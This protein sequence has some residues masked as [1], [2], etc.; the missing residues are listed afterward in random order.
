MKSLFLILMVLVS[1]N[2]YA[3]SDR[4]YC[5]VKYKNATEARIDAKCF[6]HLPDSKATQKRVL[7]K[8]E[9]EA[10][11]DLMNLY[12]QAINT[13]DYYLQNKISSHI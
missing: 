1:V 8:L 2:T 7:T 10:E 6:G 13:D 5:Q 11:Y 12:I 9:M 4:D 3:K